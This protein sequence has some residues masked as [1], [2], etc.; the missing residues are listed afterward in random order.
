METAIQENKGAQV[1]YGGNGVIQGNKFQDSFLT[2]NKCWNQ[3]EGLVILNITTLTVFLNRHSPTLVTIC[4]EIVIWRVDQKFLLNFLLL[5]SELLGQSPFLNLG[6][7]AKWQWQRETE[8]CDFVV[9]L[10]FPE[11]QTLIF[12]VIQAFFN[13]SIITKMWYTYIME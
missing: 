6:P 2:R 8:T 3:C 4:K 11:L 13:W 1:T 7:Q 5:F 10:M 12:V 9:E